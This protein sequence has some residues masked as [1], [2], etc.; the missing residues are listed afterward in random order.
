MSKVVY[1][2]IADELREQINSGELVAGAD[3][4]TE[5]E[6]ADTWQ[7]SRGPVRNALA[8]LR[9]EGLIE[10]GRGRPARV[11]GRKS[12]QAVDASI[13]FTRWAESIGARPGAIT[14]QISRRRAGAELAAA[15][16][17][18]ESEQVVEVL[19]LR[20]LD[21]RPTMLER[22]RY[23]ADVGQVLFEHDLDAV[24]ITELLA[25]HGFPSNEVYHEIDAVSADTL[26]SE[27]LE[28]A[29]G[30]PVLRL[31]RISYDT[32]HRVYE[33]SDDHYR[34]D[35]VR[36]SVASSGRSSN[37]EHYLRGLGS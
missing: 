28:T 6:L 29:P 18:E 2:R 10:T 1:Q 35:I 25:E 30:A 23:L 17:V 33:V 11:A 7:T 16:G 32:D 36:F 19:R 26:D 22:L 12:T 24:S 14:Q 20:L 31:H 21:G 34:S 9:S 3:V 15:F 27:L 4:P 5:A 37:G 13:P 8:L